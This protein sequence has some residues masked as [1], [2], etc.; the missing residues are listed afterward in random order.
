MLL[1]VKIVTTKPGLAYSITQF[2]FIRKRNILIQF[3][4]NLQK[5]KKI[6]FQ[7]AELTILL[8]FLSVPIIKFNK[9]WMF[10]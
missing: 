9:P 5:E 1:N 7:I 10:S 6:L 8:Q 2:L 3:N 4:V